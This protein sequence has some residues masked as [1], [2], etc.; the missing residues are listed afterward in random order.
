MLIGIFIGLA[1]CDIRIESNYRSNLGY[2][3][4]PRLQVRGEIDFLNALQ[5]SLLQHNIVA[6]IKEKESTVRPKPILRITKISDLHKI[7]EMIPQSLADARNQWAEF[8]TVIEI[9][10][11]KEHLTL[12]GLDRILIIKGLI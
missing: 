3:V 10:N 5:R 11:N 12:D 9:M 6:K 8:R 7:C 4:K 2:Q 1:N